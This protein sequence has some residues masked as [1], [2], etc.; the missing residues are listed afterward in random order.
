MNCAHCEVEFTKTHS[1]QMYCSLTCKH[2]AAHIRYKDYKHQWNRDNKSRVA[3]YKQ[4]YA[5]ENKE[6][7]VEQTERY[8]KANPHYYNEYA[9][10]RSRN[11]KQA[12]PNWL[13]ESEQYQI[14]ELYKQASRHGLEVDHIIPIKHKLVCGLHV[15]WNMQLLT[16][17]ENA[18]KS[19]KFA[20]DED[21]VAILR[22]GNKE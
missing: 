15:P 4:K 22:K 11:V 16:R 19:N 20:D 6:K 12:K 5:S 10:L 9:S 13:S 18:K 7:R 1:R 8:R 21:V 2:S 17:S 3:S 14:E